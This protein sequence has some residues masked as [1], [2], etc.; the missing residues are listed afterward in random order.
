[1][2]SIITPV[3]NGAQFIRKNIECVRQ[4]SFPFEHIIVDGGSTDGTL[5]IIQE[6]PSLQLL[7]QTEKSGMYGA[8]DMGF[9]QA[10]GE[11]ICWINCDD[12]I[13]PREYEK[14]CLWTERNNL[15]FA[16][17]NGIFNY[18]KENRKVQ[19]RSTKYLKCFLKKG[20]FPFS[21][22]SVIYRKKLY[23]NS[24]GLDFKNFKIAGDMDLFYRMAT[25]KE[26]KFGFKNLYTSEFLK[27]GDSL[28]DNNGQLGK[29]ERKNIGYIPR[30]TWFNRVFLKLVR[31]LHI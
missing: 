4:L 14:F 26:A 22:P 13:Y 16:S 17:S 15:D 6:Y 1:M 5:E 2:I 7:H 21:Q 10:I 20:F 25:I 12:I 8:I 30:V 23:E 29:N 27:Y 28:G 11:Y 9:K 18:V 31:I 3:F 24:G 19:V